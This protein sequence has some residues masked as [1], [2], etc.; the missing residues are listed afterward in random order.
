MANPVAES[1]EVKNK[2][3]MLR[4]SVK[5][6]LIMDTEAA[7]ED[8]VVA[9]VD[10]EVEDMVGMV[11]RAEVVEVTAAEAITALCNSCS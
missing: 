6:V 1:G 4:L 3:R 10:K 5:E 9:E 8:A 7:T 2:R 11:N